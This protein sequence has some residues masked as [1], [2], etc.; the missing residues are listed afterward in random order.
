MR[1]AHPSSPIFASLGHG[2]LALT[3]LCIPALFSGCQEPPPPRPEFIATIHYGD[4]YLTG[5]FTSAKKGVHMP[6]SGRVFEAFSYPAIGIEDFATVEVIEAG[7]PNERLP[8]LR[9]RLYPVEA[10]KIFSHTSTAR[11]SYLFL[12]VNDVPIG[13][14]RIHA[15]I[16]S[17]DIPFA[18]ELPHATQEELVAKMQDLAMDLRQSIVVAREYAAYLKKQNQ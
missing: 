18:V 7:P 8:Y 16:S 4:K 13:I 5:T 11:G 12:L 3:M 2:L 15:P 1:N 17:G 9:V 6:E 10:S 14:H